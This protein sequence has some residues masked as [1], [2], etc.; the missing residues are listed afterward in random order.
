MGFIAIFIGP[1]LL[2]A[3][4]LIHRLPF[5]RSISETATVGNRTGMILPF[6]LGCLALYALSYAV[7]YSYDKWDRVFTAGMFSGFLVVAMQPSSSPYVD[8]ERVGLLGLSESWSGIL[9]CIGA[10]VGFGSMVFWVM[11]CF[12]K[13]D[14]LKRERTAEKN[15]RN[16]IYFWLGVA[17]ILSLLLFL[18]DLTGVFGTGFPVVF[19]TEWVMLTFGGVACLFKGGLFLRDSSETQS[20]VRELRLMDE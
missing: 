14:K 9:H 7:A 17:M 4:S 12:R 2:A 10:V 11:L 16:T 13:S 5:P 3:V 8:T 18:I 15:K 19:V 6:M 20:P 1:F